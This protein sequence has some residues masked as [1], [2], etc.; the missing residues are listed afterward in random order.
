MR[1]RTSSFAGVGPHA[2]GRFSYRGRTL[3]SFRAAPFRYP[4]GWGY[5]SW[6]VGGI[7][8]AL[9]LSDAYFI[10]N[11]GSYDLGPPPPGEHWVRYGPDALLV[12]DA[13]GSIDDVIHGVFYW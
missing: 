8:P 10:N 6:A 13:S 11:W 3:S 12:N 7:L 2:A 9:F 4:S 1:I 5:R